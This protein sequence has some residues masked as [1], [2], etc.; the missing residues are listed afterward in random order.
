[1][2][3]QMNKAN[4]NPYA[5]NLNVIKTYFRK[6]ICLVVAILSLVIL[7]FEVITTMKAPE[8]TKA[9]LSALGLTEILPAQIEEGVISF[10]FSILIALIVI[11]AIVVICYFMTYF[12]SKNSNPASSVVPFFTLLH[13]FS[14]IELILLAILTIGTVIFTVAFIAMGASMV[15]K[16]AQ[17][18]PTL[19]GSYPNAESLADAFKLTIVI[20][21]G[22]IIVLMVIG[23]VYIN[24]QTAFLQSCRR[25]C[26][27]PSLHKKGA[28]V[29]CNLSFLYAVLAL[30]FL[31]IFCLFS[32]NAGN[33]VI[34][35]SFFLIILIAAR[36]LLLGTVASGFEKHVDNN[37]EYAYAAAAAATRSPEANPIAT[38]KADTRAVNNASR[39]SQPY[40]YGEEDNK[41][42]N[43]KSSYIPEELQQ[44]YQQPQFDMQQNPYGAPMQFDPQFGQPDPYMAPQDPF[45]Q[46]P[47]GNQQPIQNPNSQNPYNNGMM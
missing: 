11:S 15:A 45:A 43:K 40:L 3:S 17:Q 30:V 7:L 33:S 1:M 9:N 19:L 25:S 42:P 29:F 20:V 34:S 2:T 8:V 4:N 10:T 39:Q 37:A 28:K 14:L 35:P 5:R 16:L 27:E 22:I 12:I 47:L 18:Y 32:S 38:Y 13:A 36:L 21:M 31:V 6:P 24:A 26:K 23:L 41:D 44:D 46:S